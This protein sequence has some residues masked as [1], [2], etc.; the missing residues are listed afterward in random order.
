MKDQIRF[1]EVE[2][3]RTRN[4]IKLAEAH[5]INPFVEKSNL[6]HLIDTLS[7][8]NCIHNDKALHFAICENCKDRYIVKRENQRA[9]S[10]KCRQALHRNK[11]K[12]DE[13]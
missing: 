8:M 12:P 11:N 10:D 5:K 13:K 4:R 6:N 2:I 7:F 1:L 9:C 3:V